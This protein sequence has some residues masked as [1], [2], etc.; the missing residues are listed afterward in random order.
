MPL[1]GVLAR[2]YRPG[3][4]GFELLFSSGGGEFI[5]QKNC[6]GGWSGLE[7][8]DTLRI[9]YRVKGTV[10]IKYYNKVNIKILFMLVSSS[11]AGVNW[12]FN[13]KVFT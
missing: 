6:P 3:G 8:T 5:H 12:G 11:S 1:G 13:T 7:L 9:H 4:G 10:Q 2:F